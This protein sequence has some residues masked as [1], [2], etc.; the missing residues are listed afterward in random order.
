[1]NE[2]NDDEFE[3]NTDLNKDKNTNF[4]STIN[5]DKIFLNG[6][7][8]LSNTNYIQ[9]SF[10]LNQTNGN[11]EI[12]DF[13]DLNNMPIRIREKSIIDNLNEKIENK[14]NANIQYMSILTLGTVKDNSLSKD[15]D[16]GLSI[17]SS[18][19]LSQFMKIDAN[20]VLFPIL[21][22]RKLL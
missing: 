4:K 2:N 9:S 15:C 5:D 20:M 8:T 16:L 22:I 17:V 6:E 19:L 11:N 14:L 18:G 7:Y 12:N 21:N 10:P 1:M 13:S 3:I